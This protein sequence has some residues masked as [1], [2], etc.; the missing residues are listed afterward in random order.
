MGEDAKLGHRQQRASVCTPRVLG[1]LLLLLLLHWKH[2]TVTERTS[3]LS[4]IIHISHFMVG[5]VS[6]SSL[7][8]MVHWMHSRGGSRIFYRI[9]EGMRAGGG[10]GLR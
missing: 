5:L 9:L 7:L 8:P 2:T 1:L 4:I 6:R 3:G 10:G